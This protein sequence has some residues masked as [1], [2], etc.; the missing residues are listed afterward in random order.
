MEFP[1]GRGSS[2]LGSSKKNKKN[3]DERT[4][5]GTQIDVGDPG[6]QKMRERAFAHTGL[7]TQS[8]PIFTPL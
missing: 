8:Y 7:G 2:G 3:T 5:P 4:G 1:Y 6:I